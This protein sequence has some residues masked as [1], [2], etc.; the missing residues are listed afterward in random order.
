M[1]PVK[2]KSA[3]MHANIFYPG[4]GE[5]KK[6]LSSTH[7]GLNKEV[8]MTL[9]NDLVRIDIKNKVGTVVPV[10]VPLS[11]FAYLVPA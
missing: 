2:L 4:V 1:E 8:S 6:E 7:D 9:L 5:I 3:M 10:L 11:N